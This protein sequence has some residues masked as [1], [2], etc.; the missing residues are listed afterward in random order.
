MIKV[1][2]PNESQILIV[3]GRLVH[4]DGRPVKGV[5]LKAFDRDLRRETFL[6]QFKISYQ[7]RDLR[8]LSERLTTRMFS[9]FFTG[10][11]T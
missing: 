7:L 5:T 1:D 10:N 4:P 8:L 2:I 11:R 3:R 6:G 9:T